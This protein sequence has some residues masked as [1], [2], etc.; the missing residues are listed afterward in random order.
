[1]RTRLT[2]SPRVPEKV[3]RIWTIGVNIAI[4]LSSPLQNLS[5]ACAC[6]RNIF[7]TESGELQFSSAAAKECLPKSCFV[8]V[9][10][11]FDAA[12]NIAVKL[13]VERSIIRL[14]VD[15]GK[16]GKRSEEGCNGRVN[17]SVVG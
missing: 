12:S 8:R 15:I 9:L 1:M 4:N 13:A 6:V 5:N 14:L 16:V 10:Y 2:P 3:K 7:K 17:S 11:S